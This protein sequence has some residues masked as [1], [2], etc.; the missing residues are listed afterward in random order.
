[1]ELVPV[2]L[3]RDALF[4]IGQ[5]RAPGMNQSVFRTQH[6]QAGSKYYARHIDPRQPYFRLG[7]PASLNIAKPGPTSKTSS[8]SFK[9]SRKASRSIFADWCHRLYQGLGPIPRN[10]PHIRNEYEST[11]SIVIW[12]KQ[13]PKDSASF[14]GHYHLDLAFHS[15]KLELLWGWLFFWLRVNIARRHFGE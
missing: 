13:T 9:S 10:N 7:R 11:I 8:D 14:L 1:M 15:Q 5:T 12:V 3:I 6:W 4:K 2:G